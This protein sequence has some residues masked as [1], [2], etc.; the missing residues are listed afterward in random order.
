MRVVRQASPRTRLR[1]A[2]HR[3]RGELAHL[4]DEPVPQRGDPR[5]LG[6]QVGHR[7]LGGQRETDDRRPCRACPNAPSAPAL[8]RAGP[9][10]GPGPGG[11]P[12]RRRPPVRRACAR[13]PSR[14]PR[15]PLPGRPPDDPPPARRRSAPARRGCGRARPPRRPAGPCRSRC[16]PTSPRP[17]R[18]AP[19]ARRAR[20]SS[21]SR[22]TV[23]SASTGSSTTC[24]TLGGQPSRRVEHRVVLHG[25]DQHPRAARVRS[26]PRPPQPLD[27]E[28]V[29]LG[30]AGGPDHLGRPSAERRGEPFTTLLDRP[31]RGAPGSVHRGRVA[32]LGELGGDR[33]DHLGT[34]RGRGGVVEVGHLGSVR[35]PPAPSARP[36]MRPVSGRF[37]RAWP[38]A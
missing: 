29:R 6:R 13:S 9:A 15:V 33:C 3:V 10:P 36:P 30:P 38:G 35:T 19:R 34:H 20:R 17:S 21:A 28:V 24:G 8:R 37:V 32:H 7:E 4:L 31:A 5:G 23:P 12:V 18:S 1:A 25:G 16:S 14:R 22:S 11:R 2:Q 26:A 27:R